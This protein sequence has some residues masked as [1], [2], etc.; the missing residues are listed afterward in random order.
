MHALVHHSPRVI[1]KVLLDWQAMLDLLCELDESLPK[2]YQDAQLLLRDAETHSLEARRRIEQEREIARSEAARQIDEATQ[3]ARALASEHEIARLA[4]ERAGE[5][6][7][8][9]EDYSRQ[10]KEEAE[11]YA[12]EIRRSCEEYSDSTRR[13]ADDYA[14]HLLSHLKAVV[15]RAQASVEDGLA[16]MKR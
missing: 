16:Q 11:A 9:A 4:E 5:L 1:G 6:V 7:R 10:L 13:S 15:T 8:N 3:R 2:E 12:A 14:L